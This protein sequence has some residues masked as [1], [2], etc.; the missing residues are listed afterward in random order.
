METVQINVEGP[1][2]NKRGRRLSVTKEEI[3][4]VA[5]P[6]DV[7]TYPRVLQAILGNWWALGL[8]WPLRAYQ[9]RHGL[10]NSDLAAYLEIPVDT[11]DRLGRHFRPESSAGRHADQVAEIAASTGCN[12]ERLALVPAD[13]V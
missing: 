13:G 1:W 5:E 9:E 2:H 7:A 3:P 11:L 8:V 6:A 10:S 12:P 4:M